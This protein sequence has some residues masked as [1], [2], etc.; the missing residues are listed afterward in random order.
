MTERPHP[1]QHVAPGVYGFCAECGL[2]L[3]RHLDRNLML[4]AEALSRVTSS[5]MG[6][7]TPDR[8]S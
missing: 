5:V 3:A 6:S 7:D 2:D 1:Y 8:A 4:V